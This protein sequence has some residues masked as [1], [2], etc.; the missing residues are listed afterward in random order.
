MKGRRRALQSFLAAAAVG[1]A[2]ALTSSST[3][4]LAAAAGVPA[5]AHPF[6]VGMLEVV[7]VT[8]TWLLLTE[9]RIRV[10]G[11]VAV[12]LAAGV[13]ATGG[14]LAYGWFGLVAPACSLIVVHL[15]AR[16][17]APDAPA[18][19]VPTELPETPE[20]PETPDSDDDR[21]TAAQLIAQ[22]AGRRRLAQE[23]QI[24]PHAARKLL[25]QHR[26]EEAA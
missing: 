26:A 8:G 3:V 23:L 21:P 25:D 4:R 18:S 13:T 5:W 1:C 6:A 14:A 20:E 22:G 11:A 16:V 9:P 19:P 7:A 17:W 24:T 10:E 12:V 2:L 15:I